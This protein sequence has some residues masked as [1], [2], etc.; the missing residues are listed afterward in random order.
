MSCCLV[1]S[2]SSM[3]AEII[4]A[5]SPLFTVQHLDLAIDLLEM[6]ARLRSST[7][8]LPYL[9]SVQTENMQYQELS[10]IPANASAKV[11]AES[12]QRVAES[13]QTSSVGFR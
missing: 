6:I 9:V 1:D 7:G 12:R 10:Y 8:R 5:L 11:T 2:E 3:P 13:V 4:T